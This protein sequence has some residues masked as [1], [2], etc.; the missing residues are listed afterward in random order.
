MGVPRV[1]EGHTRRPRKWNTQPFLEKGL[2]YTER[3]L[4]AGAQ[5]GRQV[6]SADVPAVGLRGGES[7]LAKPAVENGKIVLP[8]AALF[9]KGGGAPVIPVLPL[10]NLPK[11]QEASETSP[12]AT[13]T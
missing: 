10:G 7:H 1:H 9:S 3:C 4:P 2:G 11:I 13:P 5:T 8:S 12:E 6:S